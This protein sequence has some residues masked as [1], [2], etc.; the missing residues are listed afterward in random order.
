MRSD[1][2]SLSAGQV[3]RTVAPYR[4]MATIRGKMGRFGGNRCGATM[5]GVHA[6][7]CRDK[8]DTALVGDGGIIIR[9]TCLTLGAHAA[10][11]GRVPVRPSPRTR[12]GCRRP[13][14]VGTTSCRSLRPQTGCVSDLLRRHTR[15]GFA[16]KSAGMGTST[17][18]SATTAPRAPVA[19]HDPRALVALEN[20]PPRRS[21][22]APDPAPCRS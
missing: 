8:S 17:I 6:F 14:F 9:Q 15:A 7:T 4:G 13:W 3:A 10:P 12:Q 22:T 19:W 5:M 16:R 18:G 11:P 21:P 20:H 2:E 1:R